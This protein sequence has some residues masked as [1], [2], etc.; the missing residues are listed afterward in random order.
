MVWNRDAVFS[1]IFKDLKNGNLPL[2]KEKND[3]YVV[4][5][6]VDACRHLVSG[7]VEVQFAAILYQVA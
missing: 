3:T 4:A 1:G 6:F 2:F 7:S 5:V